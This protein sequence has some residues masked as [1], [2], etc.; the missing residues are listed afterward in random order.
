MKNIGIRKLYKLISKDCAPYTRVE[1]LISLYKVWP[2][3]KLKEL[4]FSVISLEGWSK[5]LYLKFFASPFIFCCLNQKILKGNFLEV[6]FLILCFQ[7]LRIMT[8][9]FFR[10]TE[11]FNY[12]KFVS[13]IFGWDTVRIWIIRAKVKFSAWI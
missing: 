13:N 4:V 3:N 2:W 1:I 10:S 8:Q 6:S 12:G 5:F 9:F 7:S 11:I